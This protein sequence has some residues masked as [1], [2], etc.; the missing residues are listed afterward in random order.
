MIR[1]RL[2]V[3][4]LPDGFAARERVRAQLLGAIAGHAVVV[5]AAPA[6][7]GKTTAV[8]DAVQH[9]MPPVAWVTLDRSDVAPGRLLTYLEAAIVTQVPSVQGVVGEALAAGL[10]HREA[11]GFLI[12]Q[13]ED[14]AVT[15]VLDELEQLGEDPDAWQLVEALI[16]YAPETTTLVLV[17]RHGIPSELC[18]LPW[19]NLAVIRASDLALTTEEAERLLVSSGREASNVARTVATMDGWVTGVLFSGSDDAVGVTLA[20]ETDPLYEYL[21]AEVL[22]SLSDSHRTF[23][24]ATAVFDDVTAE[25]AAALGLVDSSRQLAELRAVHLPATWADDGRVLRTH[26]FFRDFLRR[27]QEADD[28]ERAAEIRLQFARRMAVEGLHEDA[29]TT[30]L[31][32]GRLDEAAACA[33]QCIVEVVERLDFPLAER[34]LQALDGHLL[35]HDEL[36]TAELMIAIARF[37]GGRACRAADRMSP[38]QRH[39]LAT[40]SERAAA[41][42]A[43]GYMHF[44]RLDEARAL[45]DIAPPGPWIYS[46]GE[47]L[48]K[49]YDIP[50]PEQV[51]EPDTH[52]AFHYIAAY[53]AGRLRELTDGPS[54]QWPEAVRAPWRVAALRAVGRTNDA[55]ELYAR[56]KETDLDTL[57]LLVYG[58]PQLLMDAG[59]RDEA[60][61]VINE[62]IARSDADG[63]VALRCSSRLMAARFAIRMDRDPSRALSILDDPVCRTAKLGLKNFAELAAVTAAHAHLLLGEDEQA[64]AMLEPVV[65]TL[66]GGARALELPSAAVYL[67]EAAW[68]CGDDD[69]SAEAA[70]VALD[71][72]AVQGSNHLLL[73]ALAD[74]PGVLARALDATTD[75]DSAW[76]ALA[77][78]TEVPSQQ[79]TPEP[80]QRI[81]LVEFGEQRI[82]ADGVEV[83]SRGAKCQELLSLLALQPQFAATRDELLD[84]L[85][86]GRADQNARNYLRQVIHRVRQMLPEGTFCSEPGRVAVDHRVTFVAESV[87]FERQLAEAARQHGA[88]RLEL[89]LAALSSYNRGPYLGGHGADWTDDRARHLQDAATDARYNAAVI[90]FGEGR[91]PLSRELATA[92]LAAHPTREPAWRLLMRIAEAR[93][94]DDELI[95]AFRACERELAAIG[96]VPSASTRAL[97]SR[98]RTATRAPG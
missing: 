3:P 97:L 62:G 34:W 80:R 50:V 92:V 69:A 84:K 31:T 33:A 26:P 39:R 14:Q 58:A 53:N 37:E 7:S 63:S 41:L 23:L 4:S 90:A 10:P 81:E 18:S 32:E 77:R 94:E 29:T 12:E 22:G 57:A 20:G 42:M 85:F 55:L 98:G 71:A 68:R 70:A 49:L 89:T 30:F 44:P 83:R 54:S 73:Q 21:A 11:A 36:V 19:A 87:T 38:D 61:A 9:Q 45:M 79:A 86:D 60:Q 64:R 75:A 72:A 74:F 46:V 15:L 5:V 78:G 1:R 27:T 2:R 8:A 47:I 24:A 76:H 28:L 95:G 52:N 56:A 88:T 66:R 67:S 48:E 65:H 13:T 43:M 6:G 51:T 40:K 96:T 35:E 17:S 25:R 91:Y 93:G 16:R 59:R 82:L